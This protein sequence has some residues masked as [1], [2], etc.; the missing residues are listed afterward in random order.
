MSKLDAVIPSLP[1]VQVGCD[2]EFFIRVDNTFV[3]AVPLFAGNKEKPEP[4]KTVDGREL[5]TV[6]HDNVAVEF[7]MPPCTSKFKFASQIEDIR[8]TIVAQIKRKVGAN[9]Y[10]ELNTG[11]SHV[12]AEKYLKDEE[13]QRFGCDPDFNAW[14]YGVQ[15]TPPD[16]EKVGQLRAAG[17]HIHVG[18]LP[19]ASEKV[20]KFLTDEYGKIIFVQLLDMTVG[21]LVAEYERQNKS[22]LIRHVR[23][24]T[25]YGA[26]GAYRPKEYGVE[27][28]SPSS[29]WCSSKYLPESVFDA[30]Q[31]AAGL[32]DRAD[33]PYNLAEALLDKFSL[34]K[35]KVQDSINHS[36]PLRPLLDYFRGAKKE[37]GLYE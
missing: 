16:I 37:S 22:Q 33:D 8:Q 25:M 26:A 34:T 2:P 27:Y 32:V 15:N 9:C 35:E 10:I 1:F 3:S 7:T 12:F 21:Q 17:G 4:L 24:R 36:R 29:A 13:T 6:I 28:R 18:F 30:V 19:N 14:E 5:G 20:E 11:G 31:M 23:R